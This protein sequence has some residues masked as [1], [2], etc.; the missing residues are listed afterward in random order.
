MSKQAPLPECQ[1]T[2]SKL[3]SSI[4]KLA[5]ACQGGG[6]HTAFTAGVLAYLFLSFQYFQDTK[7]KQPFDLIGLS[8]TS[9]GAITAAMAW[10]DPGNASQPWA[11]GARRALRFWQN[12]KAGEGLLKHPQPL[13]LNED[14]NNALAQFNAVFSDFIPKVQFPAN[15]LLSDQTRARM[16]GDI[17][18]AL[19]SQTETIQGRKGMK[20]FIGASDIVNHGGRPDGAFTAFPLP[21]QTLEISHLLASAAI[22]ELFLPMEIPVAGGMRYFWDGLYSQNPPI[23]AFFNANKAGKPATKDDKPDL[24]WVIQ[25]NPS[26]YVPS[27]G[28]DFPQTPR[29]VEDRRNELIGNVSLGHELRQ[30]EQVNR[31]YAELPTGLKNYKPVTFSLIPLKAL[32]GYRLD[33]NSK[34]NRDTDFID[35]LIRHGAETA[36][37][38]A[39]KG[40][41]VSPCAHRADRRAEAVQYAN[42]DWP[43]LDDLAGYLK[44]EPILK[45]I[46]GKD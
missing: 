5:I 18:D 11:E 46:W 20:I 30:I 6:A 3:S 12:N 27:N 26:E 21:N 24:L 42:P 14:F 32:E 25:I 15:K 13:W 2:E 35:A 36:F 19:G 4:P 44:D 9:G 41:L 1:A 7:K 8:G 16:G 40:W 31:M 17:R 38:Y 33:Y 28:E 10:S 34:M 37:E 23:N 22:P 43:T 45:R 29:Q 39:T